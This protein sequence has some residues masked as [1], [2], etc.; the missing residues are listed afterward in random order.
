M[1]VFVSPNRLAALG[2]WKAYFLEPIIFFF[3]LTSVVKDKKTLINI[4]Y[5]LGISALYLSLIA[6]WQKFLGGSWG[7][8]QA[9]LNDNETV[10]RA[11]SVFGY[12]NALGL[13]LGPIIMLYVFLLWEKAKSHWALIF[14]IAII[15]LSCL[16]IV[17]A[18]S[19]GAV[20]SVVA[21][22]LIA[23]II[24]K[25]ARI[26]ALLILAAGLILFFAHH[27]FHDF[28]LSKILL[29]DFSGGIRRTMW[30]ETVN[31]L[32]DNWLWGAG[33]A[34]Y[35]TKII[36]YH[37][38]KFFEIYLYPHNIILN[39]WSELGILGLLS[40]VFLAVKNFLINIK[41]VIKKSE[42]KLIS[43][44]LIAIM[45]QMI[46]HGMVDAPYFKNDLSVM[47]WLFMATTIIIN[48]NKKEKN[49]N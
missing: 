45:I 7:I 21:V 16:A 40:F 33:L 6:V 11:T 25:K 20:F 12:P 37:V 13:Y 8:S 46:I 10:D 9:F 2:I 44:A 32:K 22:C 4:F 1:A 39:F 24:N 30:Q 3:C 36:P 19:E 41:G 48:G 18:Q 23:A 29:H 15:V 31:M 26:W 49:I 43:W 17:L 5:V 14:K 35:Q 34:G 47:F 42:N 38:H 28:I 27:G